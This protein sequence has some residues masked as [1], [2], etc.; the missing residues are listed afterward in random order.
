MPVFV[1]EAEFTSSQGATFTICNR[2]AN[3]T[4]PDEPHKRNPSAQGVINELSYVLKNRDGD[5]DSRR[6]NKGIEKLI[7]TI[8]FG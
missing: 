8:Q 3:I 1:A 2:G 7:L 5:K 6:E 4:F